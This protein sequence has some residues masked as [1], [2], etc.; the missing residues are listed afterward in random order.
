MAQY[1][2]GNVDVTNG[3]ATVTGNG[4]LWLAEV[5]A[6]DLFAVIGDGV[7][8]EVASVTNDTTLVL[9]A[10]YAGVTGLGKDYA[11][12][13]DFTPF[14]KIPYL[15]KGDIDTATVLKRSFEVLDNYSSSG[16]ATELSQLSDVNTS[17]PTNR[18]VL[19][20]D[21]IDWESRPLTEADI[22]DLQNYTV[23][24]HTH[25]IANVTGLQSEL[26]GKAS[27]VHGHIIAD[28]T[29]LQAALDAKAPLASPT[30]TG[31]VTVPASSGAGAALNLVQG[32]A[33]TTPNNGDVWTTSAGIYAH[34]GG[35]T[36]NL[37]DSGTGGSGL[38]G[39]ANETITGQWTFENR[40]DIDNGNSLRVFD[41]VDTNYIDIAHDG[42]DANITTFGT[43]AIN[44]DIGN[45]VLELTEQGGTSQEFVR[46]KAG[47]DTWR[48]A[49]DARNNTDSA[50]V[51]LELNGASVFLRAHGGAVTVEDVSTGWDIASF[52]QVGANKGTWWFVSG[53]SPQIYNWDGSNYR[54][55][56]VYG[57]WKFA[58]D[59]YIEN[60]APNVWMRDTN[61][62]QSLDYG[63][64]E[65]R[66]STLYLAVYDNS[67]ATSRYPLAV[68]VSTGNITYSADNYITGYLR[69]DP[70]V[71]GGAKLNVQQ[72]VAP[73]TPADGDIWCDA[74]GFYVRLS[75]VTYNLRDSDVTSFN[76]RTGAITPQQEDYDA[77][78]LTPAEGNAAY[79]PLVHTH[80]EADITDLGAYIENVVEDLTPELGADLDALGNDVINLDQITFTEKATATAPV[81][82]KGQIW[83]RGDTPNTLIFTDDTGVDYVVAGS[84]AS[85]VNSF[86]GRTGTV[87]PLQADYD[88]FFLTPTEGD[89]AYAALSHTHLE[90]DIT[91]LGAY[92]ENV[93]EDTTPQLGGALDGQGHDLNNLGVIFL[94]EQAAA[95]ADVAGK[96]QL[97]VKTTDSSLYFTD[98][99]GTDYLLG[100][101]ASAGVDSFIGRTGAVVAV[102][103]DYASF[104]LPID[105]PTS[106]GKF[107]TAAVST[108]EAGFNLPHGTAPTTPV[109]GDVW[110]TSASMYVRINGV[111][112]D[113]LSGG[114]GATELVGLS[115]VNTSTPTN[116][117]VL[118]ADGVD[119]E[120]RALVEADISDL[121]SYATQLSGLSDVVSATNTNRFA[122]MANGTTGYV[123]R[124]IVEADISDLQSYLL[125]VS[126]DATPQLGGNL[127]A[128]SN[129]IN[130]LASLTMDGTLTVQNSTNTTS[131][132]LAHDGTDV[133]ISGTSTTTDINIT[134]I[135]GDVRID[136]GRGVVFVN[137]TGAS[138]IRHDGTDLNFTNS[139]TTTDW[140][141]SGIT[142]I[143]AGTVDADFDA[144]TATSYGGITEANLL[145]KTANEDVSGTYRFSNSA[146]GASVIVDRVSTTG[147]SA[148]RFDNDD[149]AKGYAGFDDAGYFTIWDSTPTVQAT[150]SNTGS[151]NLVEKGAADADTAGRGQ[152]W[153]KNNTPN[154]L[155]YTDDAGTDQQLNNG[156]ELV[157]KGTASSVASVEFTDLS[158]D[159]ACYKLFL[160]EVRPVTDNQ[161]LDLQFSR[162]NGTTWDGSGSFANYWV[163]DYAYTDFSTGNGATFASDG[164][165]VG[166]EVIRWATSDGSGGEQWAEIAISNPMSTTYATTINWQ[167]G[168][169]DSF[170]TLYTYTGTGHH[171]LSDYQTDAFR[172]LF[173]S[174]NISHIRYVLY[175]IRA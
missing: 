3:S 128:N 66:D 141:I 23:T 4:T 80:V 166:F 83:V 103:T 163:V 35:T 5:A 2:S 104:Y 25:T 70:S 46:I 142:S 51:N 108:T 59:V 112:Q 170:G 144:I 129:S 71:A 143:Q 39:A 109:N 157:A 159:Y 73:T 7:T 28:V 153:V 60:T 81:A 89:A 133:N 139:G 172:I 164:D 88:S 114:G 85:Y 64:I 72:G 131:V 160:S 90:A 74:S 6:G 152:I 106:T 168:G 31:L 135:S 16:G 105:D 173:A 146:F 94:T 99:G 58:S 86:N 155:F 122:L 165:D 95:E 17:T 138:A 87:V 54:N 175:G 15:T 113:L 82:A 77:F 20:A 116:R 84:N 150:V 63:G 32:A 52:D 1:T 55:P 134:G 9:T 65:F 61:A 14:L 96:G 68:N 171:F 19:V 136:S 127:N 79:A 47:D 100:G 34:V 37:T 67:L 140:N 13:R 97:W 117:N 154:D 107:T 111:T 91:D 125:A 33:P 123:G 92:I 10:N 149:G 57:Q 29:G 40:I 151:L 145:D 130:T 158:S 78:F 75:G 101:G 27:A 36:Y 137:G 126:G 76:T 119:W 110:T 24:G 147:G 162:D 11:I 53:D 44:F 43:T 18:N 148:I 161:D 8:Y 93:V 50:Y 21:G 22:S 62:G 12:T 38:D 102:G 26:D 118:V 98:D 49:I 124:A 121:Q 167:S 169:Y 156:W 115:D 42:T 174:G 69:I 132:T 56:T 30:F 120:S 48:T 41:N 45:K